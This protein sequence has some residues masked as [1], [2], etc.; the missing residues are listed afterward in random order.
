MCDSEKTDQPA[1]KSL[2]PITRQ[3]GVADGAE[4]KRRDKQQWTALQ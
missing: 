2:V 1:E 3:E 4:R